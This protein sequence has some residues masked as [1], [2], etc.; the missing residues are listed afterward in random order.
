[1]MNELKSKISTMLVEKFPAVTLYDQELEQSFNK[2]CF[3]VQI[4]A[5]KQ[6]KELNRRYRCNLSF[7]ISYLSNKESKNLDYFNMADS[8]YK[9]LEYI[10]VDKKLYRAV[11]MKYEITDGVLHFIFQVNFNLLKAF[12]EQDMNNLEVKVS[13]K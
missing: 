8:L 12:K 5:S 1:M 11:N 7:D 2:P 3:F 4:L 9:L 6:I 10:E 13:G